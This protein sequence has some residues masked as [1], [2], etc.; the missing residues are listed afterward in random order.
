LKRSQIPQHKKREHQVPLL[1][2]EKRSKI[3]HKSRLRSAKYMKRLET[4]TKLRR[5][6]G[7]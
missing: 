7:S 3:P 5:M 2:R 1:E 4:L 6:D